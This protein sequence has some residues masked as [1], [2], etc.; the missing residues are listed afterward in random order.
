IKGLHRFVFFAPG[1]W[2]EI[3]LHSNKKSIYYVLY[4]VKQY[5]M[6]RLYAALLCLTIACLG[7]EASAGQ[8]LRV[9]FIGN[10]YIYTNNMPQM[11]AD[12]ATS[13]GDTLVYEEHTPGG[14]KLEDH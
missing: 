10:S 13:M 1:R 11:L 8:K 7:N 4:T 5:I 3:I 12:I 14:S 9:Y 2:G 6:N